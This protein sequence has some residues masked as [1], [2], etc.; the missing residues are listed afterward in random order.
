MQNMCLSLHIWQASTYINILLS[1][2]V[3]QLSGTL[4]EQQ[5]ILG[6]VVLYESQ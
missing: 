4:P 5:V 1:K 6:L 2:H 3:F